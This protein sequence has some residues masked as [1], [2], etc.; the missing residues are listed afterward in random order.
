MSTP[1]TPRPSR[2][3]RIVPLVWGLATLALLLIACGDTT[4]GSADDS[5]DPSGDG[6]RASDERSELPGEPRPNQ[7]GR[8]KEGMHLRPG[9]EFA[10][11]TSAESNNSV[12]IVEREQG[13][14][15]G[16]VTGS[17]RE[18]LRGHDRRDVFMGDE[19]LYLIA[20]EPVETDRGLRVDLHPFNLLRIIWG[21]F[22]IQFPIE[23]P[24]GLTDQPPAPYRRRDQKLNLPTISIPL[25]QLE[26]GKVTFSGSLNLGGEF[27]VEMQPG[28]SGTFEGRIPFVTPGYD[29]QNPQYNLSGLCAPKELGGGCAVDEDFCVEKLRVEASLGTRLHGDFS[30]TA[31]AGP[32]FSYPADA[33]LEDFTTR[34]ASAGLTIGPLTL[35]PEFFVGHKFT[36]NFSG[37]ATMSVPYDTSF[38]PR[39]GFEYNQGQGLDL[40]AEV[41]DGPE[42]EPTG[43]LDFEA[44][45]DEFLARYGVELGLR[46]LVVPSPLSVLEGKGLKFRLEGL[47][48]AI[49]GRLDNIYTFSPV[50]EGPVAGSCLRSRL[51]VNPL[52][53]S[54]FIFEVGLEYNGV[55]G[56]HEFDLVND[57]YF[58]WRPP[59][60][61]PLTWN[62]INLDAGG[63]LCLPDRESEIEIPADE[64]EGSSGDG[65]G[66]H[67]PG[68]PPFK[69]EA[70][71]SDRT[72][73]DLHVIPPNV[74]E[75]TPGEDRDGW[76]HPFDVCE[77]DCP[78]GGEYAETVVHDP[79][80]QA[81]SGNYQ[82]WVVN[83]GG[84]APT[85]VTVTARVG[86]EVVWAREVRLAGRSGA[87]ARFRAH[88]EPASH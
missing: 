15:V 88:L 50:E 12:E 29:C 81:P 86:D 59:N 22:E 51:F 46:W 73:V 57:A 18:K 41:G 43:G 25:T 40:I 11:F 33:P 76:L 5:D 30:V 31:T 35:K 63:E 28:A 72:D 16:Y 39:F 65:G 78:D 54:D 84:G 32:S 49:E 34:T 67:D 55:G 26:L 77:Q 74:G 79:A 27:N 23:P 48:T 4:P 44:G 14:A 62:P 69:I 56:S 45:P 71:W 58:T 19:F 9:V 37:S 64:R 2:S 85:E 60:N 80:E 7:P 36:A 8:I 24:D 6:D 1:D 13:R 70:V 87:E 47:K 75:L 61:S 66:T 68:P 52:L 42:T 20:S 38:E 10:Q 3:G 82:I 83:D 17:A 21:D 53:A